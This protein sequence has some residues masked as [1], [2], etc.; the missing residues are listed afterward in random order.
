MVSFLNPAET[1]QETRFWGEVSCNQD[2]GASRNT[3]V[4]KSGWNQIWIQGSSCPSEAALFPGLPPPGFSAFTC[5]C[6]SSSCWST[7]PR[8]FFLFILKYTEVPLNEGWLS[9]KILQNAPPTW[10]PV[11]SPSLP[12]LHTHHSCRRTSAWP[13]PHLGLHTSAS[14]SLP[15][16]LGCSGMPLF[17]PHLAPPYSSVRVRQL[18]HC[19]SALTFSGSFLT[20]W[21]IFSALPD[22][23]FLKFWDVT[24][25]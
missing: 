13:S 4:E 16:R 14:S 17:F 20:W 25:W 1:D 6:I 24:E 19:F 3:S 15:L 18:T 2:T 8:G 7:S 10:A 22:N 21:D 5:S 12:L 23:E 9:D 11:F